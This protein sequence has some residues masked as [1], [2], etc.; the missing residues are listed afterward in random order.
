M[1]WTAIP[2]DVLI[3]CAQLTKANS[4]QGNKMKNVVIIYTPWANLK[5][6]GDMAVGQVSFKNPQL[7]KRVHVAA[8]ENAIINRLMKTRVEKFPDLMAEQIAY[9]SEKKRK[10]KAEA[11]KKAKEE[12]AIA[13]E[14]KAASDAYKH[15]YDDLFNEENMRSTGWDEDDFM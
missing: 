8:R 4:I 1:D 9:D 11:I 12:E 2:E 14:R 13:K 5:K 10:A 15:A 6:T 3:D 7:V